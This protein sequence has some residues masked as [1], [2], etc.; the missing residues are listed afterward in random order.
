[1]NIFRPNAFKTD[2]RWS[3]GGVVARL[4]EKGM[5]EIVIVGRSEENLWALPKG[6]PD[7]GESI[8]QT[9]IR[10]VQEETGLQVEIIASLNHTRYSFV[11][12]IANRMLS[13][14][15]NPRQNVKIRKTVHWYL[16]SSIGGDF[17]QHDDEYD[18]V[19]WA[20]VEEASHSLTYRSEAQIAQQAVQ[21]F[22]RIR[23]HKDEVRIAGHKITLR[24]KRR[25][26]AWTDYQ[27]RIDP[28]LS[29]LDATNPLNTPFIYFEQLYED[30]VLKLSE[31]S[32]RFGIENQHGKLIGNCMCYD[33]DFFRREAEFGIMIGDREHWN[34]GYGSDAART[35]MQYVFNTTKLERIYLHTL[36]SNFRAQ[37]AFENA[38]FRR[39][40]ETRRDRL[41]FWEM[42]TL[43]QEW[44]NGSPGQLANPAAITVP[45]I[46]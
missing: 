45:V 21:I 35:A 36:K 27:W 30:Q 33:I 12:S 44:Q 43:A 19:K 31:S 37:K 8:E 24:S 25:A 6:S 14:R 18:V 23:N 29:A 16:M 28:E 38:G 9:A 39:C 10:E 26:D 42:E 13:M 11:H 5:P 1:M 2:N 3:A 4:N 34:Q 20:P 22:N 46:R 40:G 15:V 17:S 32:I 41:D 7:Q